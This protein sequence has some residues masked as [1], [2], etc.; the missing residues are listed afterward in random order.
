MLSVLHGWRD[1]DVIISRCRYRSVL[2]L[3]LAGC[4]FQEG[5][6]LR[7][8][9]VGVQENCP[10]GY[11]SDARRG[12][13]LAQQIRVARQPYFVLRSSV[14]HPCTGSHR[15]WATDAASLLFFPGTVVDRSGWTS[16]SRKNGCHLVCSGPLPI[17]ECKLTVPCGPY[18]SRPLLLLTVAFSLY[19]STAT[20]RMASGFTFEAFFWS[21][22]PLIPSPLCW[23]HIRSP[24]LQPPCDGGKGMTGGVWHHGSTAS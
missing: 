4:R 14:P 12:R 17:V 23:I 18:K 16:R 8:V 11:F 7:P 5:T 22:I 24:L 9:H 15:F 10:L 20:E 2:L 6:W 19:N 3:Y 13:K 21:L 1:K